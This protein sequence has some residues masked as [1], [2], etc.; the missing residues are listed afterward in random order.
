MI[1]R[2]FEIRVIMFVDTNLTIIYYDN[3]LSI[4]LFQ[5]ISPHAQSSSK[6]LLSERNISLVAEQ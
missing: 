3:Y 6:A 5:V 2:W 4:N 1:K